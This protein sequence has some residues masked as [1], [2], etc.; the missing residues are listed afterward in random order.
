MIRPL[1]F[2][3][4]CIF[5]CWS[6]NQKSTLFSEISPSQSGITF[7]NEIIENDSLNI[8]EYEYLYNGGGVGMGDFDHN[9]LI[10]LVFTGSL[11]ANKIYLNQG[12]FRFID[13]SESAGLL[14]INRWSTSVAIVDINVDG[15]DDIYINNTKS[16]DPIQRQNL[17]YVN[18]G[19]VDGVLQFR[20]MGVEYGLNDDSYSTSCA[21]FD[22]DRDGDLDVIITVNEMGDTRNPGQY[23]SKQK[24]SYQRVDRLYRNDFNA[25]LGHAVFT[26][27][28]DEA[29]IVEPGFSLSVN[30]TDINRDGWKDIYITND[31]LS[32]DLIYI[33]QKDGTFLNKAEIYLKHTSFSAMGCDIVDINNDGFDDILAL[34]MLPE[35]N[36][37]QKRLL[38]PTNYTTYLNNEKYNYSYQFVRNTLQINPG[39][40]SMQ[41]SFMFSDVALQAGISATDWSWTP[42]VADFDEDG[43]RDIIITNGFPKD[44]TDRDYID[45]RADAYSYASKEILLSKIPSV[46]IA[47]YAYRNT[48]KLA[49]DNVTDD[50]GFSKKTFSTGA[51]YGDLDNDGD[52]DVV[53]NNINDVASIYKNNISD[54]KPERHS[55]N[56]DLKGRASNPKAFGARVIVKSDSVHMEYE[57]SPYRGYRSTYDTKIHFGLGNLESI[58]EL[59]IIW[60]EGDQTILKDIPTSQLITIVHGEADSAPVPKNVAESQLF[61][62]DPTFI[63]RHSEW[64]YIDYNIQALLPHKLS[65]LGPALAAGDVNQDGLEDLYVSGS[66]FVKGYF[67]MQQKNGQYITDTFQNNVPKMEEMGV[68]FFDADLDGDLDMYIVSGSYEFDPSD[69]I[70]QDRLYENVNGRWKLS[71]GIPSF[72]SSGSVVTG[73]DYDKDGDIDL[74]VGG[75]LVPKNFPQFA[76]SALLR[77]DSKDGITKFDMIQSPFESLGLISSAIWTDYNND[78]WID[79]IAVGEFSPVFFFKN[80]NGVLIKDDQGL[81]GFK[82]FWNSISAADLDKDGDMDYVLGNRGNNVFNQITSKTPYRIYVSDFDNN[83]RTDG[84]PSAYFKNL[85]GE[86]SEFPAVSRMD[87]AKEINA[88]R[89]MYPSYDQYARL[90]IP[91]L[92]SDT[93][94]NKSQIYEINYTKS[95]IMINENGQFRLIQLPIEAQVA[96]VFGT[97]VDDFDEDGHYDILLV[98]N[99]FSNELIHGRLDALNGLFLKGDG[100]NN[101]IPATIKESGFYVPGDAKSMIMTHTTNGYSII[102]AENMGEIRKFDL[103]ISTNSF[104]L[105]PL[106][107]EVSYELN[108]KLWHQE[109]PYGS[110]YLSSHTRAIRIPHGVKS[111]VITNS[112]GEERT[113][114]ISN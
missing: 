71:D 45:Y 95:S 111:L 98:G 29:G 86:L 36:Y 70:L 82:G 3:F 34:D 18:Q 15:W 39:I 20:E 13:I 67:L 63:H 91:T 96:P 99:D 55:L 2:I 73:A 84:I 88:I 28:S 5:L 58:N 107:W 37:R 75:R 59:T 78:G 19:L 43:Y 85:E 94:L 57:H 38:G 97:I 68:C 7:N 62:R 24:G 108:G 102:T 50:W 21:F 60:P 114:N 92:F 52:L 69:S 31:F 74:F 4:T 81:G 106:D 22:Y 23:R 65:Q 112:L 1:I 11:V 61:Q 101:F 100:N 113:I 44:V 48:G 16:D 105:L 8:L 83:G 6:C 32:D 42:L 104:Q 89:K 103:A 53:I 110:G 87:F 51:A 10:D 27:V 66:A 56:V 109:Y 47:N 72:L 12:D 40:E 26:N 90:D 33:N 14:D 9:G 25:A 30:I 80:D 64:D 41:D 49:F 46:K 76:N 77:N 54:Q 93:T 79:L 17:L 35:D